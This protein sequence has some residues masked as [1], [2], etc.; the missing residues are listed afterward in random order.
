MAGLSPDL[1]EKLQELE[2]ELEEGDITEKGYGAYTDPTT[3]HSFRET[4]IVPS[5]K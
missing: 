3:N 4:L 5:R 1:E 2:K